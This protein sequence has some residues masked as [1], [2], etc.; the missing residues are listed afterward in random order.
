MTRNWKLI[1]SAYALLGLTGV[2][3]LAISPPARAAVYNMFSPGGALSGTW[4]SQ[5]VNLGAGTPFIAGNLPVARLNSGTGASSSTFW[6]GDG[7]WGAPAS[8]G[9]PADATYITQTAN[10]TLTNEQAM[11]SLGTGLE[12]NATTTGVQSIYAGTSCTNQFTRSLSA[13]GVATCNS[14]ALATDVSGNL[15]VGNL[16]SGSGASAST[17]WFGDGT[18]KTITSGVAQTTG[19]FQVTWPSICTTVPSQTWNYV[20]TGSTVTAVMASSVGCTSNSATF[21]SAADWPLA[22]RPARNTAFWGADITDVSVRRDLGCL[23]L[24]TSGTLGVQFSTGLSQPC[25]NTAYTSTGVK[26]MSGVGG[27]G[28]AI[29]YSLN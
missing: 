12:L 6:R 27:L 15:P 25:T 1:W 2:G 14:V 29:T 13:S 21:V 5:N 26:A 23:I 24:N 22:L 16:N 10:A 28:W 11:G 19:T 4:N 3:Y 9:A 17:A 7:T 8:T 18:W 20:L